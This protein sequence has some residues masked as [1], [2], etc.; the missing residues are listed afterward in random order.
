MMSNCKED[1]I[2]EGGN[3]PPPRVTEKDMKALERVNDD[4]ARA[5]IR[6]DEIRKRLG[7]PEEDEPNG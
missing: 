2:P 3:V 4:L 1:P 5:K 7:F 6:R